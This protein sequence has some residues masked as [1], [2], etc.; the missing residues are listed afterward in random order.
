VV[1][2]PSDFWQDSLKEKV[3]RVRQRKVFQNRRVRLDEI[4]LVVSVPQYQS[5]PDLHQ[6][7]ESIDINW[8]IIEEQLL[9]WA[10]LV[11]KGKQL[12]L[13]ISVGYIAD[14]TGPVSFR[15]GDKRGARMNA[16]IS[17]AQPTAW[18]DVYRKMRC[19]GSCKN[20]DWYCWQDPDGKKHYPL[21]SYHLKR[22]VKLVEDGALELDSHEDVPHE[23]R[24]KL[25]AKERCKRREKE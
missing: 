7:S 25:Y 10:N 19:P 6:Q 16:E 20:K 1:L 14:D 8:T 17:S 24:E 3:K 4:T 11:K 18:R 2:S 22:L 23:I 5:K 21:D 9:D 13:D 12:R 15:G